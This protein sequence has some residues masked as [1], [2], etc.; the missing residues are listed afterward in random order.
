MLI[1]DA[2]GLVHRLA[3]L[4]E[5]RGC[6]ILCET[7]N[8]CRPRVGRRRFL[9]VDATADVDWAVCVDLISGCHLCCDSTPNSF[10]AVDVKFWRGSAGKVDM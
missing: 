3:A 4:P 10:V 2:V 5:L 6:D 7:A 1:L 8:A 9:R